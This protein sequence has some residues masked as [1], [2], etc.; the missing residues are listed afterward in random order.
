MHSVVRK[1]CVDYM[2]FILLCDYNILPYILAG[3]WHVTHYSKIIYAKC[4]LCL[5][6]VCHLMLDNN[7]GKCGLIFKILSPIDS[8][9]KSWCIH[10]KDFHL[11]FNMLLHYLVKFEDPKMLP[12][13]HVERDNMFN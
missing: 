4:T 1:L 7:C 9:E 10:H 11:T 8:L 5:K 3:L 13:F 12:N 6:K 2:V